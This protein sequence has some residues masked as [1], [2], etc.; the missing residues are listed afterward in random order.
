MSL[1]L[2]ERKQEQIPPLSPPH[3]P[4]KND[5]MHFFPLIVQNNLRADLSFHKQL[6]DNIWV[7]MKQEYKD[8]GGDEYLHLDIVTKPTTTTSVMHK[9]KPHRSVGLASQED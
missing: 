5:K 1:I 2:S 4:Q 7:Q 3:T 6:E 9:E 8:G